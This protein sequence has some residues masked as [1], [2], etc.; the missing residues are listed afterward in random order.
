MINI[1]HFKK[2]C[3]KSLWYKDS[4]IPF[5]IHLFWHWVLMIV[6]AGMDSI[7]I[8]HIQN[9]WYSFVFLFVPFFEGS[10]CRYRIDPHVCISLETLILGDFFQYPN[11]LKLSHS[12]T[13]HPPSDTFFLIERGIYVYESPPASFTGIT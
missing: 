9:S 2:S 1:L 7:F 6:M 4:K 13:T 10:V 11:I 3:L 8:Y 5:W 12:D